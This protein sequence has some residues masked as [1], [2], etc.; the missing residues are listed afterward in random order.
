LGGHVTAIGVGASA[1]M[2]SYQAGKVK[3][4]A[5]TTEKRVLPEVPTLQE[6]GY[7]FYNLS[8]EYYLISAPKGIA[9]A[10]V[11]KL[12][13]AFLKAMEAPEFRTTAEN[14]Y[15]YDPK[16]LSRQALAQLIEN[17]YR[18]NGEIIQKAKLG[19]K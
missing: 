13:G 17:L 19:S 2:K 11:T 15:V 4:L 16:P 10:V 9:A 8:T 14:F 7:P 1:W 12:E 5:T 6:S 18:K 3:V